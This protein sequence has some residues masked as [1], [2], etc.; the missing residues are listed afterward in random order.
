MAGVA[1]VSS[2]GSTGTN[3]YALHWV[4]SLF[5]GRVPTFFQSKLGEPSIQFEES[6]Y[7]FPARHRQ[8]VTCHWPWHSVWCHSV[9]VARFL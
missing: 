1:G 2:F 7:Q 6:G 8:Q 3:A 4:K 9:G 5:A